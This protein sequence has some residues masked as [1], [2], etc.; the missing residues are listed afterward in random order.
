MDG[1]KDTLERVLEVATREHDELIASRRTASNSRAPI[2]RLPDEIL[3]EIFVEAGGRIVG[4]TC[5]LWRQITL[6]IPWLWRDIHFAFSRDAPLSFEM[7][8]IWIQRSRTVPLKFTIVVHERVIALQLHLDTI[9]HFFAPHWP[10]CSSLT[11][12]Y[13]GNRAVPLLFPSLVPE[14]MPILQHL[15]VR[16]YGSA[17]LPQEIPL[18]FYPRLS[19]LSV[20]SG[21]PISLLG[22]SPSLASVA[23]DI[24]TLRIEAL[25]SV[26]SAFSNLRSLTWSCHYI[27]RPQRL[28][29]TPVIT[30][31]PSIVELNLNGDGALYAAKRIS[32]P[33]VRSLSIHENWYGVGMDYRKAFPTE[34][35][36]E[37]RLFD[38]R[39]DNQ[40]SMEFEDPLYTSVTDF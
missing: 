7:A 19:S 32:G 28:N 15:D 8:D 27:D 24:R 25:Q 37:L 36:P 29:D 4:Y 11:A 38:V 18:A 31:P 26:I 17:L 39:S 33:S 16:I 34:H 35:F 20:T 13:M 22:P 10:R 40:Y 3:R 23:L 21:I 14:S 2:H 30:L 5:R 12:T 1:E 6:D 9:A